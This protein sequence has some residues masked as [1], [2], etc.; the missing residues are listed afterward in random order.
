MDSAAESYQPTQELETK[1]FL[2]D[3]LQAPGQYEKWL[4]R[5]AGG[6]IL[7]LGYGHPLK[8][9]EEGHIRLMVEHV[10]VL[11]KVAS[12]GAYLVETFPTLA[13]L[14]DWLA[15]FKRYGKMLHLRE[16]NFFRTLL[17]DVD[18]EIAKGTAAETSFARTY[19]DNK[20]ASELTF[21]EAAYAIGTLFEA[22]ASTTAA[23]MMSFIL[24]MVLYPKWQDHMAAEI[25]SVVGERMPTFDDLPKLPMVRAVIKEVL[26]WRPVTAGGE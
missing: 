16:L 6:L 23:S 17:G 22:G 2:Y 5:F 9:G 18:K 14:P 1:R 3:F 19:L 26:R 12:P 10:H 13:Y 4:E 15:P 11:E 24:A 8:T 20:A 7:R 25:D 21:D